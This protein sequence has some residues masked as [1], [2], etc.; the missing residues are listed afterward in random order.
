MSRKL[1]LLP[2][3]DPDER[4]ADLISGTL[5]EGSPFHEAFHVYADGVSRTT[6]RAY[7][8]ILGQGKDRIH[9]SPTP[10]PYA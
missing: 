1:D 4:K 8:P 7:Q 6:R 5:G 10:S 9:Q 2:M 3:D